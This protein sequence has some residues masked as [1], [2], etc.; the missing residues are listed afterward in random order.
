MRVK[1][2]QRDEAVDKEKVTGDV[3]KSWND[4]A[5]ELGW[6]MGKIVF[7]KCVLPEYRIDGGHVHSI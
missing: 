1:T 5:I 3:R 7:E 2:H 4:L 6:K